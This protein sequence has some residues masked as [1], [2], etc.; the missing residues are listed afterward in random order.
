MQFLFFSICTVN[1][2]DVHIFHS[3]SKMLHIS[4]THCALNI[5]LCITFYTKYFQMHLM[6]YFKL[7][8]SFCL[9]TKNSKKHYQIN[10]PFIASPHHC[11]GQTVTSLPA[12]PTLPNTPSSVACQRIITQVKVLITAPQGR[13]DDMQVRNLTSKLVTFP[14]A[15]V[16]GIT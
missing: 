1:R 13:G 12:G 16:D 9:S 4:H 2:K 14:T 5:L 15:Q 3:H 11:T 10:F 6:L 8:T 7:H